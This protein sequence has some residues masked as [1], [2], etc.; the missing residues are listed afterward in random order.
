[1]L[2][3]VPLFSTDLITMTASQPL[4]THPSPQD[5]H[6]F[7]AL[8]RSTRHYMIPTLGCVWEP[9]YTPQGLTFLRLPLPT[10]SSPTP[11]P[12]DLVALT[13]Q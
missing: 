1:M 4:F 9:G 6:V 2:N 3:F 5:Q 8:P 13:W 10:H 12:L 11:H 7:L